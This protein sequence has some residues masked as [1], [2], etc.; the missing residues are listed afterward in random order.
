MLALVKAFLKAGVLAETRVH[1]D[2]LTGTP[3]GGILSPLLANIALSALDE[4]VHRPWLDGGCSVRHAD[5]PGVAPRAC[6][7]G[8]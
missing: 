2:S 3:Q 6:R 7:A 4:H 8:G 1:E 5:A